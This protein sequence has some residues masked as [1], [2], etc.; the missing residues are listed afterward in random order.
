[1]NGVKSTIIFF[2]E[3][4]KNNL[5]FKSELYFIKFIKFSFFQFNYLNI[6]FRK[7]YFSLNSLFILFTPI[8]CFRNLKIKKKKSIKKR[9][10]K[11]NISF[12]F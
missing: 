7:I 11:K 9:L 8:K 2:K 10:K 3:K 5:K 6:F 12:F 4:I 1:M